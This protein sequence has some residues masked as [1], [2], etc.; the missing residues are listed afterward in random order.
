MMDTSV[1][2]LT[3]D[4]PVITR[5]LAGLKPAADI[6]LRYFLPPSLDNLAEGY[7]NGFFDVQGRAP[8]IVEVAARLAQLGVPMQG[9]FGRL[10]SALR[11]DRVKDAQA[12]AHHYDVSNDFYRLWLDPSMVYSCAYFP[13]GSE[14]LAE[15][16]NAKLDH[17][18]NKVM[19]KPGERVAQAGLQFRT[20]SCPTSAWPSKVCRRRVWKRSMWRVC[21]AIT[22]ERWLSGPQIMKATVK[23]FAPWSMKPCTASG[24]FIPG[25]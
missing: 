24:A 2:P 13:S 18:L 12:I 19:L 17:I 21:V 9:R 5:L 14:T 25:A 20:V 4:H 7:V 3:A 8:D 1:I 6:P 10:F 23:P 22:P 16:Q 11:H 15:A